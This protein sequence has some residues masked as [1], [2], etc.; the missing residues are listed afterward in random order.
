MRIGHVQGVSGLDLG[1]ADLTLDLSARVCMY[2]YVFLKSVS[3]ASSGVFA[4][5]GV[6]F[7]QI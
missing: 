4:T 2:V 6:C 3:N 5:N 1:M 7:M